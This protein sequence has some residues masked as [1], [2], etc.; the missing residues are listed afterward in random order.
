MT[1]V[2][3]ATMDDAEIIARQTSCVQQLHKQALPQIFKAPSADLFPPAKLAALIQDSN[4]VVAVG[5]IDGKIVGHIYGEVVYRSENAF[6][7]AQRHVYIHQIGVDEEAHRRGVGTALISFMRER[8]RAMGIT[9]VQVDHWAFNT[10][11]AAF[12]NACGFSP[13]KVVMQQDLEDVDMSDKLQRLRSDLTEAITQPHWPTGYRVRAF[14]A[15]DAPAV[16]HLLEVGYAQGGGRVGAFEEWWPSLRDDDEFATELCFLAVD[17][18]Q[19]I[20][21]VAQCWTSAF[22]KDL[23]VHPRARRRGIAEALLRT[24]FWEF[25]RRGAKHVDLKVQ[26][27]NPTGAVRLYKKLGMREVPLESS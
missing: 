24:A 21:G 20:V 18:R 22:I 23:A 13:M 14:T 27:D 3:L 11:A 5:E 15:D 2:R 9:A 19:N 17:E 4:C 7:H 6:G 8:A 12:F 10:R 16:H 25:R 1:A 26:I